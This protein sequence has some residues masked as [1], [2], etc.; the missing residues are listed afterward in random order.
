MPRRGLVAGP[1]FEY[2]KRRFFTPAE[3][4]E[5]NQPEDLWVS[6]LGYVYDLTPLAEE[7]KGDLLLKPIVEAAG[8]DISHWFDPKT[9]DIRK[10]IDPL[11]GCLRY[12]TPRGRFVH[13]PPQLPRSDWANDFG[14]PWWLGSQYEV[15]RLSPKTRN[16]R[17]INT[18]TSQEHTLE[19]RAGAGG[20]FGRSWGSRRRS[21]QLGTVFSP[22]TLR[23]LGEAGCVGPRAGACRVSSR[24][25]TAFT[26]PGTEGLGNS[27]TADLDGSPA[28]LLAC[29]DAS[30]RE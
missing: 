30:R 26:Q 24:A 10:H 20:Q 3:V 8:Q 1:E 25:G 6:Y 12:R 28:L 5:H 21:E 19:V 23:W 14:K 9:K 7:Y 16:I 29:S 15:G 18:L 17:I 22:F 27:Y 2:F 13:V 4:A 11:T